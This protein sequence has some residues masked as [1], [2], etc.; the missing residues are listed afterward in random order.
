MLDAQDVDPTSSRGPILTVSVKL[1]APSRAEG[2]RP[3]VNRSI[4][5]GA[6]SIH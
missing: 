5:I 3:N 4:E 2:A 1:Y 6:D